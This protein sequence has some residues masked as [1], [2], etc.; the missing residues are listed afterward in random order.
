MT[1][2]PIIAVAT[3]IAT[4]TLWG[5]SMGMQPSGASVDQIRKV[6]ESWSPQKQID[7]IVHSPMPY[8][9]KQQKIAEIR[10]KYHLSADAGT[11][12]P[13]PGMR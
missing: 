3:L 7:D 12:S 6:R 5:C 8:N 11:E 10:A 1:S 2:K 9:V 4:V 13:G